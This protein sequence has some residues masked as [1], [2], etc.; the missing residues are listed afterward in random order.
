MGRR[1]GWTEGRSAGGRAAG[2]AARDRP[3][4]PRGDQSA[5]P[6]DR[7]RDADEP[8]PERVLQPRQGGDGRVVRAVRPARQ[9]AGAGAR[10]RGARASGGGWA[11]RDA[12]LALRGGR[13][14]GRAGPRSLRAARWAARPPV[15]RSSTRAIRP[16]SSTRDRS[17]ACIRA[18]ASCSPARRAPKAPPPGPGHWRRIVHA[19]RRRSGYGVSAP[20]VRTSGPA[21]VIRTLSERP[22]IPPG[23]L[24]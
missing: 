13:L 11:S 9:H 3:D 6:V 10:P 15:Q 23:C 2:R 20:W 4:H 18:A 21:S 24:R 14:R 5:A 8:L 22:T 19:A 7:R 17:P 1:E 16:R 12:P